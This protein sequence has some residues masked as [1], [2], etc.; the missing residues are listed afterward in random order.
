[1][2]DQEEIHKTYKF[3]DKEVESNISKRIPLQLGSLR[4]TV[5]V[6]VVNTNVPLLLSKEKMKEWGCVIDCE[7]DT[8]YIGKTNETLQMKST[9]SGHWT[10]PLGRSIANNKE[11]IT[12]KVLL[13]SKKKTFQHRELKKWKC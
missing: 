13:I 10:L 4:E 7:K 1:M 2:F 6:A 8:I 3:G 11:E 12:K 9:K 5:N